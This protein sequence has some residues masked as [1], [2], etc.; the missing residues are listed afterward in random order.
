MESFLTTCRL[1]FL[2]DEAAFTLMELLVVCTL[3]SIMLVISIPN[4][5]SSLFTDP[6]R[7]STRKVVGTVKGLREKAVRKQQS[8][9]LNLDMEEGGF[10]YDKEQLGGDDEVKISEFVL[11]SSVKIVDVWTKSGGNVAYGSY[12]LWISKRGYM[13]HTVITLGD[14]SGASVSI[15]LSPFL[16]SIK[17]VDEYVNPE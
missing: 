16:G 11:P 17:V 14:D 5:R 13:D 12:E 15:I 7:V 6:I 4:M 9:I 8:V 1:R 10:W 2:R 3:I